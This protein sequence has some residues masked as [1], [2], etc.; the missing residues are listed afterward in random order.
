MN[1]EKEEQNH[2]NGERK[3]ETERKLQNNSRENEV[4]CATKAFKITDIVF[5]LSFSLSS[6]SRYLSISILFSF[7][8]T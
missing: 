5:Y 3:T 1:D 4:V 7:F 8:N 2:M 6:S